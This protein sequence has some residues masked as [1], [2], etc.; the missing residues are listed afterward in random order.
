LTSFTG[1]HTSSGAVLGPYA[2]CILRPNFFIDGLVTYTAL[3]NNV[4]TVAPGPNGS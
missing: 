3:N 2:F 4:A 1:T